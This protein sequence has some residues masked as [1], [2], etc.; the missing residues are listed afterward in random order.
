MG[1]PQARL[2]PYTRQAVRGEQVEG[3]RRARLPPRVRDEVALELDALLRLFF[4]FHHCFVISVDPRVGPAPAPTRKALA[5]L[6]RL[7]KLSRV[8]VVIERREHELLV[9]PELL[10]EEDDALRVQLQL[11]Y[12]HALEGQAWRLLRRGGAVVLERLDADERRLRDDGACPPE[13]ALGRF[14]SVVRGVV[15]GGLEAMS[16]FVRDWALGISKVTSGPVVILALPDAHDLDA[17]VAALVRQ[18][19][20][21]KVHLAR[22]VRRELL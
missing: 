19:L 6:R 10:V 8:L 1:R 7:P 2:V 11:H 3:R 4:V 12:G 22:A 20:A 18:R 9:G 17:Q 5:A 14:R 13:R 16:A 15:E 21:E